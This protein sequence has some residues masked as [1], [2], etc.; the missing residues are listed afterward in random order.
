MSKPPSPAKHTLKLSTPL[1]YLKGIGPKLAA[2]FSKK[3]I[4]TV[5]DLIQRFPRTYR[6]QRM[7]HDFSNLQSGA[8]VTMYGTLTRKNTIPLK[9]HRRIYEMIIKTPGGFM[10][11]KY[12][13]LPFRGYFDSLTLDRKVKVSGRISFYQQRPEMHHPDIH[14]F[15]ENQ[16]Q[17]D[18]LIPVYAELENIS[19]YKIRN[20]IH[21]ALSALKHSPEFLNDPLP[22]TV[23]KENN[24]ISRAEAVINLH[25]PEGKRAGEYLEFRSP[26]QIRFIFEEFFF[27]QLY[28]GLKKTGLKK[29]TAPAMGAG[30]DLKEKLQKSLSFKLTSAQ[31][32]V[33]KEI[34][35][36]LQ[37]PRPMHRLVQGDVGCGKTITAV[38]ACCQVIESQFQ[39]A[40]M[41]PTEILAEQH[42]RT[43]QKML[44]P[45]NVS[46]VLLTG[47]TKAK[48]K[49]LILNQLAAGS[50]Q[51]CVGTHALIQEGVCFKNLGF[52]VIDEQHRFGAHQRALL[53]DKGL[54]PHFLVM[55]A[56]P[57]PRSLA[58][59]LYG[60]LDVSVIDEMPP[61]R[62]P[63]MTRKT[64]QTRRGEVLKFLK[65][66][67]LEGRQA[68][69]V[70]PLVEESE[71]VDLKNAVEEY[72][73]LKKH[74]TDFKVGLLHGRMKAEEKQQIMGGFVQGE[75]QILVSTTVIE[76]G[77]D[78]PN[79]SMMIVEHADRFG[80][81]QLHQLRG[82]V[83]RGPYESYCVL[84]LSKGFSKEA[85]HR[86]SMMEQASDG[87]KIAEADL[88]LRGPGEFL[89]V[90]QS[91][92]PEFKMANL[93][94]DS[95]ILQQAKTAALKVIQNDPN[96]IQPE[97]RFLKQEMEHLNTHRLP[98]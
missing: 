23:Q 77:V 71:H 64:Y 13:R 30:A 29:Q 70:Y 24:L 46:C 83:G 4:H 60:D 50:V 88:E 54:S 51:L 49:K 18:Q 2:V 87:F 9:G 44:N 17:E 47:K 61:G 19:Q 11:C 55:T 36:D 96:F 20:I 57:I 79:A 93:I 59:T 16:K 21:T 1:Q 63:I 33:L 91:G 7:V 69:I 3:N 40:V 78:V 37:S 15:N 31:E 27:L 8:Y 66:R 62:K 74:F 43:M 39:C 73:K 10:A 72:E 28:M 34:S 94:R 95:Q 56:T 12:F 68:Y 80:L 98:G 67:I 84:V 26:A 52:V 35:Q 75:I 92:L 22:K 97:N 81:S 5:Q 14:P 38:L 53:K 48:E 58:L 6:D 65:E 89:G 41:A 90:R 42:Y 85:L 76:V 82:R 32:K 25:Q 45:L 86:V